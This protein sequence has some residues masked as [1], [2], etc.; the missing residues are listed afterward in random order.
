MCVLIKDLQRSGVYVFANKG[1]SCGWTCELSVFQQL[2]GDPPLFKCLYGCASGEKKLM[3]RSREV[4]RP[5]G[6]AR[7]LGMEL[8][9]TAAVARSPW[10]PPGIVSFRLGVP[11]SS[12]VS[13]GSRAPTYICNSM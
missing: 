6:A 11:V 9:T 7:M 8:T 3:G 13:C 10:V 12:I 1:F 4:R 5:A 2:T